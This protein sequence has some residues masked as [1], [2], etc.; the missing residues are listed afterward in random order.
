MSTIAALISRVMRDTGRD[1]EA[2]A[3]SRIAEDATAADDVESQ[4]LWRSIRAP[5]L[6][7]AGKL[8]EAEALARSAVALAQT[9]DALIMQGD[10]ARELAT[11]LWHAGQPEESRH[12][13]D[14]AIRIYTTKGDIVSA[15][16]SSAWRDKLGT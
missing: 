14:A 7:R 3:F 4:A 13:I 6:A 5:I 9:T 12:S 11:V 15:A 1:D 2:I 10:T 16:R 8:L